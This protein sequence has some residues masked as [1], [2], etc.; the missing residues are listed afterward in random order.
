MNRLNAVVLVLVFVLPACSNP[1]RDENESWSLAL[2][3]D[4]TEWLVSTWG[5]TT[6]D[7]FAVGGNL[8]RGRILHFDGADWSEESI[9]VDLPVINWVFGFEDDTTF[10]VGNAGTILKRQ[11]TKWNLMESPTTEDLWG[12]WGASADDV[13]AV[14]GSG[15]SDAVATVVHFDGDTWEASDLPELE[16]AGVRAFFKVWGTSADNVYVVG[17]RGAVLHYDGNAWQ[18]QLVGASDD[19]PN[20]REVQRHLR[21]TCTRKE[22]DGGAR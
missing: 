6:D 21:C 22:N 3:P 16:R 19:L 8:E 10:A 2:S 20:P 12:I 13:W 1:A 15:E 17:Q 18:E 9:P 5:R 11:G 14:G 7:R 4:E